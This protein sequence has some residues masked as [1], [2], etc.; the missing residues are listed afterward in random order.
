MFAQTI[1]RFCQ[2]IQALSEFRV[3][4]LSSP[5]VTPF[6][7][8]GD[9]NLDV[10][11]PYVKH[12]SD[13]GISS[14]FVSGS[15]GEGP[16]LTQEERKL[17][18]EAWVRESK[19]ILDSVMINIGGGNLRD[20]VELARHA[21]EIGADAIVC[22]PPTYFKPIKLEDYVAYMKEVAAA[23]PNLPFYLYDIKMFTGYTVS[24]DEFFAAANKEIP[25]LRGLKHTTPEYGSMN[26]IVIQHDGKFNLMLGSDENILEG[27]ALGA[28]T[29]VCNSFMGH[30][31]NRLVEAFRR[32]D[33]AAARKEQARAVSIGNLRRKHGL[34]P[35]DGS[36]AILQILGLDV[37]QARLPLPKVPQSV[38]EQLHRDLKE[39]G[40]FEW[41]TKK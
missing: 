23:A 32:G 29:T 6:K 38:I 28:D 1:R 16:N 10:I 14:L 35:A 13:Y 31:L 25:T 27:L 4:G 26:N 24:G 20:S 17:V 19:G 30:I 5:P 33:I 18:A 39:I 7:A 12:M 3:T 9:L 2:S 21:Q 37:G 41:G 22:V 11:K 40:F 15:T 34:G 8:N 36:K